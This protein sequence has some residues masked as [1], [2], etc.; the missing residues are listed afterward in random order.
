VAGVAP[1]PAWTL[2]GRQESHALPNI[3][4]RYLDCPARILSKLYW[5]SSPPFGAEFKNLRRFICTHDVMHIQNV[6][7]GKVNILGGHSKQKKYTC[8]YVL[9][10]T[11]SKI[12]RFPCTVPKLL[13]IKRYYR[14][15]LIPV[16]II[17]VT[18][19][20]QFT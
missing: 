7:R 14:Q 10:Q 5:L 13:I 20:I 6:P 11:N 1:G 17:Q 16:F 18:K 19:F 3:E 2:W 4:S 8:T 15:F 12:E 9:F